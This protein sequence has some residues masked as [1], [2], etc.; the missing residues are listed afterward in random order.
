MS[1]TYLYQN[2]RILPGNIKA[3]KLY[4]LPR[5]KYGVADNCCVFGL[6]LSVS[7]L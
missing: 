4:V 3:R 1:E 5:L 7:S 2:E 6:S